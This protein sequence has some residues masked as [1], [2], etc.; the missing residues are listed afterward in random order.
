MNKNSTYGWSYDWWRKYRLKFGDDR[1]QVGVFLSHPNT[2]GNDN[3]AISIKDAL[4][5]SGAIILQEE[6]QF[7]DYTAEKR[8]NILR[9]QPASQE[10][11]NALY[12]ALCK[13]YFIEENKNFEL[14]RLIFDDTNRKTVSH[15]LQ[16]FENSDMKIKASKEHYDAVLQY[17]RDH[18]T[19]RDKRKK[20]NVNKFVENEDNKFYF[21]TFIDI[22]YSLTKII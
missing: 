13:M 22:I 11:I 20:F 6:R 3:P 8:N 19:E 1:I 4:V 5:S 21:D 14:C 7:P 18:K 17:I 2:S 10:A 12:V 16:T 9:T 15:V